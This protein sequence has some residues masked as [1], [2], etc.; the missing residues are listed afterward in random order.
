MLPLRYAGQYDL[1]Y[2][3][4][5]LAA[6]GHRYACPFHALTASRH[7]AGVSPSTTLNLLDAL[8]VRLP[9][10]I[11]HHYVEGKAI[12]FVDV[13][14]PGCFKRGDMEKHV[15]ATI[16][17]RYEAIATIGLVE[18]H[19]ARCHCSAP[20]DPLGDHGAT[21]RRR[22]SGT[23]PLALCPRIGEVKRRGARH[24][25]QAPRLDTAPVWTDAM[26]NTTPIKK[27]HGLPPRRLLVSTCNRRTGRRIF[28][29]SLGCHQ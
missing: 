15:W 16:I 1:R 25:G 6:V 7:V 22:Q 19:D 23:I 27:L 14:H 12:T 20:Y 9:F 2:R 28:R 17:G 8:R 26:P 21:G 29:E 5:C 4:P 11:V 13:T 3:V 24:A 10:A 18:F